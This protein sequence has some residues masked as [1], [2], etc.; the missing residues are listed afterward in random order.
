M[1]QNILSTG[2]V[3]ISLA[4][5]GIYSQDIGKQSNGFVRKPENDESIDNRAKLFRSNSIYKQKDK[6]LVRFSLSRSFD[7][8]VQITVSID[9][10]NMQIE[11]LSIGMSQANEIGKSK[12]VNVD[13][14]YLSEIRTLIKTEYLTSRKEESDAGLDGAIWEIEVTWEGEYYFNSVW[15]PSSGPEYKLGYALF[16]RASRYVSLGELY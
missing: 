10:G 15:S 12:I 5:I 3:L 16:S 11:S 9:D 13:R 2:A 1:N 4:L 7:P 8:T 14:E 6:N